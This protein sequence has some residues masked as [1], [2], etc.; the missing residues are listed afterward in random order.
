LSAHAAIVLVVTAAAAKPPSGA[1]VPPPADPQAIRACLTPMLAAEFDRDW[2]IVLD[3][4]KQS[5]DLSDLHD[6]LN[7]WR[8]VAYMEMREPGAY[9]RL[10]AK[11]EQILRTGRRDDAVSGEDVLASIRRRQG[12]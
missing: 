1:P 11:A 9:G 12:R 7:K 2:D 8:H 3:R 6:L 10:L 5:H 4:V